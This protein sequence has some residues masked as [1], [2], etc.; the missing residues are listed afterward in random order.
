MSQVGLVYKYNCDQLKSEMMMMM[1][2]TTTTTTTAAAAAAATAA[3]TT[4]TTINI[5]SQEATSPSGGFQA[6]PEKDYK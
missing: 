3:T 1:T 5:L 2:T 4:T 6:G